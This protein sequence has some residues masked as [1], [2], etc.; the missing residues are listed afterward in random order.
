M[1]A[2]RTVLLVALLVSILGGVAQGI[3]VVQCIGLESGGWGGPLGWDYA[4][5]VTVSTA[6]PGAI[7]MSN[8]QVGT[9]DMNRA[10]YSRV[11][12]T[13]AAGIPIPSWDAVYTG[14]QNN[15]WDIEDHW[16]YKT[17]HGTVSPGPQGQCLGYV[18]WTAVN[19]ARPIP[20]GTSVFVGFDN[21]NESHDVGWNATQGGLV[22]PTEDWL[23]TVS[24]GAGPVHG[25][26]PEPATLAL[27]ALGGM[28]LVRRRRR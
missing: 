18:R 6:T 17:A 7:G 28:A 4:Y 15:P 9:D 26:V 27:L 13:D 8:F 19:Q 14:G 16:E 20:V 22:P 3:V 25:P 24:G 11:M 12:I 21:P 1:N 10:N 5:E 23:M 2:T